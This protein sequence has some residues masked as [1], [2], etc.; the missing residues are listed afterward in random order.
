[1]KSL[2]PEFSI[3]ILAGGQNRRFGGKIKSFIE[4]DGQTIIQRQLNVLKV[5]TDEILI[6]TNSS[7][8]FKTYGIKTVSDIFPRKG[9]LAGIH[10]ALK[11]VSTEWLFVVAGDLPD[12]AA[13]EISYLHKQLKKPVVM[14][15]A[16][17]NIQ[18]L[19]AFYHVDLIPEIEA[20]FQSD[21][22]S[23]RS[24][25]DKYTSGN[26]LKAKTPDTYLNIND[27]EDLENYRNKKNSSIRKSS[28]Y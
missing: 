8:S 21:F 27:Y 13:D 6:V 12:I 5:F 10:A 26:L 11:A 17:G 7:E 4:I 25:T 22:Y 19:H 28:F 23:I 15:E 1:M 20:K 3:A 14:P 9:P 16:L 18:T 24:V 2:Y